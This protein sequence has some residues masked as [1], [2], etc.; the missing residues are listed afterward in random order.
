MASTD[1]TLIT[2]P[3]LVLDDPLS[4]QSVMIFNWLHWLKNERRNGKSGASNLVEALKGKV[5]RECFCGN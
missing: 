5:Q 2:L 1:K 4:I 3:F